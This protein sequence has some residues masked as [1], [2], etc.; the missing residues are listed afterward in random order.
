MRVCWRNF[1]NKQ[2][3]Q[4]IVRGACNPKKVSIS[5]LAWFALGLAVV[6]LF[7]I[8]H[9]VAQESGETPPLGEAATDGETQ[10]EPRESGD[11]DFL[12]ITRTAHDRLLKLLVFEVSPTYAHGTPPSEHS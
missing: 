3:E 4:A 1:E 2:F 8:P 5:A 10:G 12:W 9:A 11:G 7:P 6:F